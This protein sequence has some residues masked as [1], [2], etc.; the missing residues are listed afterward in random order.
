MT[1]VNVSGIGIGWVGVGRM[2]VR[3]ESSGFAGGREVLEGRRF[4]GI[5][6]MVNDGWQAARKR[7]TIRDG[8]NFFM[9]CLRFDV[10]CVN[11]RA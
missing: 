6:W 3:V 4:S 10:R 8:I 1:G 9:T 11:R 2:G 7:N 5:G